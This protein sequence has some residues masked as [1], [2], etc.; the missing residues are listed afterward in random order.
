MPLTAFQSETLK[1]LAARRSPDS[2][3]AGGTVL[4]AAPDSPRFSKDLDIFHDVEGSVAASADADAAVL[5]EHGYTVEWQM[6]EAMFR[7]ADVVLGPERLRIEWV[8]DSAF[9]FFPVE[10]DPL[11]GW[12]LNPYDAATNK[13]LALMGRGE[14]RDYLDVLFLH[15]RRLSVGALC[16]AAAGKDPGVNPFMILEECHRTTHFRPEQFVNLRLT[17]PIDLVAWKKTWI[18]ASREAEKLFNGLPAEE[19]GCLYLNEHNVP[20]T[21]DPASPDFAKLK[22]HF[23]S[24]RGAW[25]VIRE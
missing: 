25:P 14:P 1:L 4:N 9:R 22:R 2:F 18:A 21:P 19:V 11:C 8:F 10:T 12:R 23:G 20:V 7:R 15:Q 17:I 24:V 13:M 16:W 6:R 3:L 5:R